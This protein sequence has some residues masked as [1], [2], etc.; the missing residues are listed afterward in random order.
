MS[1]H[2]MSRKKMHF[3]SILRTLQYS[4]DYLEAVKWHGTADQWTGRDCVCCCVKRVHLAKQSL[5]TWTRFIWC[6]CKTWNH[7]TRNQN[8]FWFL[9]SKTKKTK[10]MTINGNYETEWFCNSQRFG[11]CF[12]SVTHLYRSAYSFVFECY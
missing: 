10:S 1:T 2:R 7:F 8:L 4:Q 5:W 9:L 3:L 12:I 6:S 11:T